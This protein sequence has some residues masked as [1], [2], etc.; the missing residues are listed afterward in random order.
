MYLRLKRAA[1]SANPWNL[2]I[3]VSSFSPC[4]AFWVSSPCCLRPSTTTG[5][6]AELRAEYKPLSVAITHALGVLCSTELCSHFL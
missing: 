3:K 4:C 6:T 5:C 2:V 1:K